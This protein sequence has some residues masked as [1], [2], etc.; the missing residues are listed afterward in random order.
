MARRI[1]RLD[2]AQRRFAAIPSPRLRF[3]TAAPFL[4]IMIVG[5]L[6]SV[7][8]MAGIIDA[9]MTPQAVEAVH[10]QLAVDHRHRV[11]PYQAGAVVDVDLNRGRLSSRTNRFR[12]GAGKTASSSAVCDLHGAPTGCR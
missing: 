7:E 1:R 11:C 5:A 9:S 12:A 2:S 10:P 4:A 3:I 8:V 6:V